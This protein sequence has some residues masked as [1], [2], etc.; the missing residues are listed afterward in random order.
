[1]T[2]GDQV[3]QYSNSNLELPKLD[4]TALILQLAQGEQVHSGDFW[5]FCALLHEGST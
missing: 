4:L 5:P 2:Y 3:K 1:M